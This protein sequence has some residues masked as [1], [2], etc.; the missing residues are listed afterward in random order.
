MLNNDSKGK[1]ITFGEQ[2]KCMPGTGRVV[3]Y[4]VIHRY[5]Y[6]VPTIQKN[7]L[8]IID[9]EEE[10]VGERNYVSYRY[11]QGKISVVLHTIYKFHSKVLF[12]FTFHVGRKTFKCNISLPGNGG[13]IDLGI[14]R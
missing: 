6:N 14:S 12:T 9:L 5:K 1:E 7:L 2:L 11:V 3:T 10:G 8:P 13:R 4:I